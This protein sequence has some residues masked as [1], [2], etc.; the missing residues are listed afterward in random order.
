MITSGKGGVGKTTFTALAGLQLSQTDKRIVLID[1]DFGLRNL[2]IIFHAEEKIRYNIVD[3]LEGTSSLQQT[4]VPLCSNL[5]MIPGTKDASYSLNPVKW[6]SLITNLS[7]TFDYILVDT[8]AGITQTHY[9]LF[10]TMTQ[11]ILITMW[12]KTALSDAYSMA[13]VLKE[14]GFS[15][16][17]VLNQMHHKRG[18]ISYEKCFASLCNEVFETTYLGC[19]PHIKNIEY[20]SDKLV[21]KQMGFICK[22]L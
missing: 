8:P 6:E 19:L 12:E 17:C 16:G 18:L 14:Q 4:L 7:K 20:L 5:Y 2:D 9:A 1:T 15:I 13:R 3:V 21:N 22:H 10:P 11:S